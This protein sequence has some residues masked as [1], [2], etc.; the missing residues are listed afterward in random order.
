[1]GGRGASSGRSSS[2]SGVS[3][4]VDSPEQQARREA[5]ALLRQNGL[6]RYDRLKYGEYSAT[7]V[8]HFNTMKADLENGK[9]LKSRFSEKTAQEIVGKVKEEK[10]RNAKRILGADLSDK[11]AVKNYATTK[12]RLDR[13]DEYARGKIK[14]TSNIPKVAEKKVNGYGEATDREITS[15]AYKRSQRILQRDVESWFGFNRS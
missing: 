10:L 7:A 3:S 5:N 13:I 9:I 2:K 11:A 14:K 1:M 12:A 8:N 6:S 4:R 15:S